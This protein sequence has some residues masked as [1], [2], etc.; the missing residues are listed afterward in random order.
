M[1][2]LP[3]ETGGVD[4]NL[5]RTRLKRRITAE[6]FMS[7]I[8]S[9]AHGQGCPIKKFIKLNASLSIKDKKIHKC[10]N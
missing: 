10:N 4:Q 7:I 6:N 1:P 8:L 3:G 2:R 9:S 5:G